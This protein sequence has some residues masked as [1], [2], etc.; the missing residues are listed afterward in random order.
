VLPFADWSVVFTVNAQTGA[1]ANC[2]VQVTTWF[3]IGGT[4]T[5]FAGRQLGAPCI[6]PVAMSPTFTEPAIDPVLRSVIVYVTGAPGM[7]T[8]GF[9]ESETHSTMADENVTT[10]G[11]PGGVTM[12][13]PG[14]TAVSAVLTVIVGRGVFEK[15]FMNIRWT[16]CIA[17]T[18]ISWSKS[19]F[20]PTK[21][22]AGFEVT[23]A[24]TRPVMFPVFWRVS[25]KVVCPPGV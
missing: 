17:G 7:N 24:R 16:D 2:Q 25:V 18:S 19:G 8:G 20:P 4:V 21:A 5:G 1:A 23:T 6:P 14:P 9:D 15:V 3:A 12:L 10:Q 13:H 22:S 11:G